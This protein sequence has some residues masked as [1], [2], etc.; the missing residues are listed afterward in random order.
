MGP[1][2]VLA[3]KL[4]VP[5]RRPQLVAR[6]RITQRLDTTL[7]AGHRLTLVS[8]P[9]GFGKTTLLA[10]R[11]AAAEHSQ[12]RVAWLA[13][14][15]GDADLRLFLTHLV[16]AI[17]TVEPEPKPGPTR[18]PCWRPAPPCRPTTSWSA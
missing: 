17:Q 12:R 7:D 1:I 8:A 16:A 2:P 13:L 14:D 3:T 10:Q 11:L 5:A 18:S 9:A 4:F 15:E 6:P